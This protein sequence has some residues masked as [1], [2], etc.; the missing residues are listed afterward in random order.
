MHKQT[1]RAEIIRNCQAQQ[2]RQKYA[3]ITTF[4]TN[5]TQLVRTTHREPLMVEA[6]SIQH[7]R[8]EQAG[9]KTTPEERL[10]Q[11]TSEL[12]CRSRIQRYDILEIG[13]LYHEAKGLLPHGR[14]GPWVN[15]LGLYQ[16]SAVAAYMRVYRYCC[17]RPELVDKITPTMLQKI[18]EPGFSKPLRD[19][20]FDRGGLRG[21]CTVAKLMDM[22][23]RVQTRKITLGHK[24]V[25]RLLGDLDAENIKDAK[26]SILGALSK[27]AR[28]A[29]KELGKLLPHTH[30]KEQRCNIQTAIDEL[31]AFE[32]NLNVR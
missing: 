20:I 18:C 6:F 7:A 26:D 22:A 30:T 29:G 3:T 2:Q 8:N 32:Q 1:L 21:D 4:T 25:Q 31:D 14:F 13:H 23:K 15:E 5:Q 28:H 16:R 12:Q 11:I 9:T 19:E 17:G 27:Q 10:V 24:D